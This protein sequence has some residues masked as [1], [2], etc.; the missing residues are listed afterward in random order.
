MQKKF[1]MQKWVNHPHTPIHEKKL[2]KLGLE[3]NIF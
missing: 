3:R 1:I 2:Q